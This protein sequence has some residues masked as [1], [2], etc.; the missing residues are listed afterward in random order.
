MQHEQALGPGHEELQV[1]WLLQTRRHEA[2][3]LLNVDV[4]KRAT[5][6]WDWSNKTIRISRQVHHSE[7][8]LMC[9]EEDN[10]LTLLMR[11]RFKH[12]LLE[13]FFIESERQDDG[14]HPLLQPQ[15]LTYAGRRHI[16]VEVIG[17]KDQ[18]CIEGIDQ[19][20]LGGGG[21]PATTWEKMVYET[22]F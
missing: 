10:L 9:H 13:G 11:H 7:S 14:R 15:L 17:V 16:Q 18:R 4:R 19:Q 20:A 12:F 8:F 21:W 5:N 6:Y 3:K 1:T 22:S 2:Q